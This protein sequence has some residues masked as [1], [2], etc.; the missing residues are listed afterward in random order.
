MIQWKR[1]RRGGGLEHLKDR[2]AGK[3][4]CQRYPQDPSQEPQIENGYVPL[5]PLDGANKSAVQM[6]L[7][8]QVCLRPVAGQ[9]M[10]ANSITQV[11][12]KVFVPEVA[13]GYELVEVSS[14]TTS[15]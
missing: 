9:P 2:L 3:K 11:A 4:L 8:R 14:F 15:F 13:S 5:A 1:A 6:A 12:E 10:F 7:V